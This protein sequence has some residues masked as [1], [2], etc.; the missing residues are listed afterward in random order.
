MAN[1]LTLWSVRVL[2]M[3]ECMQMLDDYSTVYFIFGR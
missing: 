3:V 1:I 2:N